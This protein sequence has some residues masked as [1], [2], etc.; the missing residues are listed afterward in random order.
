VNRKLLLLLIILCFI[1]SLLFSA[2]AIYLNKARTL[3]QHAL[4]LRPYYTYSG[5]DNTIPAGSNYIHSNMGILFMSYG[6]TDNITLGTNLNY[7][8]KHSEMTT[9]AGT[10]HSYSNGMDDILTLMKFRLFK[11]ERS[12]IS[13]AFAVKWNSAFY[14]T[15]S[16]KPP[17]GSGGTTLDF[18]LLYDLQ[19]INGFQ[20]SFV[21]TYSY[22]ITDNDSVTNNFTGIIITGD[23]PIWNNRLFGEFDI[24]ISYKFSSGSAG[25]DSEWFF[26]GFL[27]L[28]YKLNKTVFLQMLAGYGGNEKGSKELIYFRTGVALAL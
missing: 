24:D 19:V 20:L 7:S 14:A 17:I 9:G 2:P 4:M 5:M 1:P 26:K 28:Q 3:K 25:A 18:K 21:P 23:V 13:G 12:F 10:T 8:F 16:E 6:L 15:D 22:L 11:D 27:G